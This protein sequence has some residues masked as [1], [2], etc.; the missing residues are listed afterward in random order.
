MPFSGSSP[1]RP[2]TASVAATPLSVASSWKVAVASASNIQ[3]TQARCAVTVST[4]S[5]Y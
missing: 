4:S 2:H 5:A 3:P 1:G